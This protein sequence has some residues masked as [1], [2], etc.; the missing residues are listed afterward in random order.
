MASAEMIFPAILKTIV[1]IL[2][3]FEFDG[4]RSTL[5][6]SFHHSLSETICFNFPLGDFYDYRDVREDKIGVIALTRS[7]QRWRFLGIKEMV[8]FEELI[9][10]GQ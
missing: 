10:E 4:G 8:G 6:R 1:R 7:A 2:S 9:C 5:A 3:W